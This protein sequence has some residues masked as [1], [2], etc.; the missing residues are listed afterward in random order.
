MSTYGILLPCDGSEPMPIAVGDYEHIQQL[1]GGTFD[2][3][4]ADF[5]PSVLNDPD[6]IIV[7][8]DE[9]P[10]TVVGY[11]HDEGLL[12]GLRPNAMASLVLNRHIAGPCVIVSGTS[13]D[14][15]Y[16]GYNHDIPEWFANAVF[17]GGLF[18]VCQ[19]IEL[20]ARFEADA[21]ELAYADG[22]FTEEQWARLHAMMDTFDPKY[23]DIVQ[24]AVDIAVAYKV[25]RLAGTV[26]K[27]DRQAFEEFQQTLKLTD[28]AINQFWKEEGK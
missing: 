8:G 24:D 13:P 10:I 21:L 28:D 4:R 3:V 14:G 15:K 20:A 22:L 23:D 25:G 5:D 9:E 1:V 19:A 17:Q 12:I 7:D 26:T 11:V 27:F 6:N 18:E 16:D 2:A